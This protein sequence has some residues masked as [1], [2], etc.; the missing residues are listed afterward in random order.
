[1]TASS[2]FPLA[3]PIL[4]RARLARTASKQ[5]THSAVD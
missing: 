1:M 4:I 2:V 5:F 3:Q